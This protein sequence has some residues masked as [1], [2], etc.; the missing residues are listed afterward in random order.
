MCKEFTFKGLCVEI[1]HVWPKGLH[2]NHGKHYLNLHLNR[3][4]RK[5]P[6]LAIVL[7]HKTSP[8]CEYF[9]VKL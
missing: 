2:G 4:R 6:I 7:Y 5:K 9:K 1:L 3:G 8:L